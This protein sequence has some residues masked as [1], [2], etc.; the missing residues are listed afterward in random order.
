MR[1]ECLCPLQ[2]AIR[3]STPLI[4]R[5]VE[6]NRSSH[7]AFHDKR[8]TLYGIIISKTDTQ[9]DNRLLKKRLILEKD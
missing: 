1:E 6:E 8:L 7:L 9:L 2:S 4:E 3:I 5:K